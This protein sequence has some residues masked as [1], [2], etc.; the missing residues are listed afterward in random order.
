[1]RSDYQILLGC[2][3]THAGE[4]AASALGAQVNI[5]PIQLDVSD[6]QSIDH[7]VKA[8]EQH[9]GR[10][11]VL[12]NNATFTGQERAEKGSSSRETWQRLFDT[13]VVGT[14]LLTERCIPLLEHSSSPRIIF[15]SHAS[16]STS[17]VLH[18]GLSQPTAAQIPVAFSS[19]MSA[20]NRIAVHYATQHPKIKV[21]VSAASSD[22][23]TA[24]SDLGGGFDASDAVRLA[25]E[26]GGDTATFTSKEGAV[27]W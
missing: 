8:I 20:V 26:E 25:T 15:M 19:S 16:A 23:T 5:N 4:L 3:E 21:N 1:M 13:N 22:P 6:D 14:A 12:I 10:I 27:Q 9:F 17:K 7:A 18:D 24:E 2:I 11:D